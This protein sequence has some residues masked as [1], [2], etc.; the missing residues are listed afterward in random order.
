MRSRKDF[1]AG[2]SAGAGDNLFSSI[3]KTPELTGQALLRTGYRS[4][5]LFLKG[6]LIAVMFILLS[7]FTFNGNDSAESSGIESKSRAEEFNSVPEN[8]GGKLSDPQN[9]YSEPV[10]EYP[11]P[12]A[13]NTAHT[14]SRVISGI[15]IY[16]P[17]VPTT[18]SY[19]PRMYYKN[20]DV[21][22]AWTSTAG[23]LVSGNGSDGIWSFTLTFADIG[24]V[25]NGQRVAYYIV[26]QSEGGAVTVLPSTAATHSD[27][28]TQVTAS[29]SQSALYLFFKRQL[30]VKNVVKVGGTG[31]DYPSLT[32]T[33]GLFY[34]INT[35][36]FRDHL[37]VQISADLTEAYSQPQSAYNHL[38]EFSREDNAPYN[39][40]ITT[41]GNARVI[42][43]DLAGNLTNNNSVLYIKTSRVI[44]DGTSQKLLTIRNT[45]TS[46]T[47]P[48]SIWPT[49]Q[50]ANTASYDTIRNCIIE[51]GTK[52]HNTGALTIQSDG[53]NPPDNIVIEN[54]DIKNYSTA[55]PG[56]GIFIAGGDSITIK[57][58]NIYNFDTTGI[59]LAGGTAGQVNILENSI[60][61]TN[62]VTK[63]QNGIISA[64]TADF[65]PNI[66]GNYFG[67]QNVN[68]GGA[69]MNMVTYNYTAITALSGN[70]HGNVITNI[71]HSTSTG[72]TFTGIKTTSGSGAV[73]NIGGL[74]GNVIGHPTTA[75]SI[76]NVRSFYAIDASATTGTLNIENTT[77]ANIN[78]Q[79]SGTFTVITGNGGGTIKNNT[80]SSINTPAGATFTGITSSG[81]DAIEGNVIS[82][83]S[84]AGAGTFNGI[85]GR[86][87]KKNQI[88]SVSTTT[89]TTPTLNV[90]TGSGTD[91]IEENLIHSFTLASTANFTGINGRYVRKNR[92]YS[93][94]TGSTGSPVI[95][96]IK[97]PDDVAKEISNNMISLQNSSGVTAAIRGILCSKHSVSANPFLMYHNSILITGVQNSSTKYAVEIAGTPVNTTIFNN[98]F[99][100]RVTGQS[101]TVQSGVYKF[102][103]TSISGV[104]IDYNQTY[105]AS[106]AYYAVL[107]STNVPFST[108]SGGTYKYSSNTKNMEGNSRNQ[109]VAFQS[110]SNLLL[111]A[112]TGYTAS[113][114]TGL[115]TAE[116]TTDI[117]DSVRNDP[118][119]VGCHEQIPNRTLTTSGTIPSSGNIGGLTL[120]LNSGTASLSGNTVLTGPLV[121]NSG[122]L[123][124]GGHTLTLYSGLSYTG[125]SI[126]GGPTS[127]LVYT[128]P[129]AADTGIIPPIAGGIA[130]M[131]V[132]HAVGVKLSS[133]L[134]VYDTL[135]LDAG[136]LDLGNNTLN[137]QGALKTGTGKM[138]SGTGST[139]NVSTSSP[140][141]LPPVEGGM[142]TL[143]IS[144]GAQVTLG[145]NLTINDTLKVNSG[146]L[147]LG[148]HRLAIKSQFISPVP[149]QGGVNSSV[150]FDGIP[151]GTTQLP[152]ITNGLKTLRVNS[153]S[154]VIQM[155]DSLTIHDTVDLA[156]GNLDLNGKKLIHKG[157]FKPGT[158]KIIGGTTHAISFEGTID[159][160]TTLPEIQ[161]GLSSLS[162]KRPGSVKL[163]SPVYIHGSVQIDSG[164][165]LTDNNT[166][167]L[168]ETASITGEKPGSYIIGT[169]ATTRSTGTS[170]ST[171]GGIGVELSSGTDDLGSVSVIRRTGSSAQITVGETSGINRSWTIEAENQ[172]SSGRQLTL[173]WVKD[174]DSTSTSVNVWRSTDNGGTWQ[175]HSG[176]HYPGNGNT[177]SVTVS[178][179]HF[180][181]WTISS[182]DNPLPVELVSFTA[183][184]IKNTV[185]LKWNTATEVNNYGF[186]IQK[187][188]VKSE[189]LKDPDANEEWETAGFIPGHG[190]SNAPKNYSFSDRLSANGIYYYR[191]K[192]IDTDGS[193]AYSYEVK[194]D[195]TLLPSQF[196]LEQNYPNPFNPE[197]TIEFGLPEESDLLLEV[198]DIT[199]SRAATLLNEKKEAGYHSVTFSGTN[200]ASGV[201]F[202]RMKAG[203]YTS[204]KKMNII[205]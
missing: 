52:T 75:N 82:S 115:K 153:P 62:T 170:A 64:G 92:I 141:T 31:A 116:V 87:I 131:K 190:N 90:I 96:G 176:P 13:S 79:G 179:T 159:D 195:F 61:R 152:V 127:S 113:V 21:N 166:L 150:E 175:K 83:V 118:P 114:I 180:S 5:G 71:T 184:T 72:S 147:A 20:F 86:T 182:E 91:V 57:S 22:S 84:M 15:R 168:G 167:T 203:E 196:F 38:N 187:L 181:D 25:S 68:G 56:K 48:A 171:F 132:S 51:G 33:T 63:L 74:A 80:I 119:V 101:A 135:D 121:L 18:G 109:D 163:A 177:R 199:G 162:V 197:T 165:I 145:S 104:A 146:S 111:A 198:Y 157:T 144:G 76:A 102:A 106:S 28:L 98:I 174:D 2:L 108:F 137:I 97:A 151:A 95:T 78:R 17:A 88:Y 129:N 134:T 60:F 139:V 47:A 36:V 148:P 110:N 45:R 50:F 189:K 94:T 142:K 4:T 77:V 194:A 70:I 29:T 156:S 202:L 46:A 49:V 164:K 23:T 185:T 103:T 93:I 34:A 204:I 89:T 112:D 149:V 160:T 10:I 81:N 42:A 65:V 27:V 183:K 201:Y 1:D 188:K 128:H 12:R 26:A 58:N 67:G 161:G 105:S 19:V 69:A 126:T 155:T 8:T 200:L 143:N 138:K 117:L 154:A 191:L 173:S 122:T 30:F 172:P 35:S 158:G 73:V 16:G 44:F 40:T 100:N 193:Y 54:C 123:H 66:I 120:N 186:E 7:G 169:V 136:T 205:K 11:E 133:S 125:G 178:A 6:W 59:Y 24:G 53:I 99:S 192:Q 3:S 37:T 124:I 39:L 85:F 9:P 43:G 107:N 55:L 41:D 32:G 130:R 140:V 14:V